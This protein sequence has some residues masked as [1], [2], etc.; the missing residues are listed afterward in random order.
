VVSV[1]GVNRVYN[2]T[3]GATVTLGETALGSDAVSASYGSAAFANK[4]VGN[5]KTIS[6]SGITLAGAD[7][8]NYSVNPSATTAADVTP[9]TLVVGAI[10]SNKPYDA[11]TAATVVLTDDRFAGDQILLSHAPATFASPGVGSGKTITVA[12]I[13]INGGAD[14]GDYVLADNSTTTTADIDVVVSEALAGTW[15][16]VPVMPDRLTPTMLPAALAPS[17]TTP[18]ISQLDL[19]LPTG[20]IGGT[21]TAAATGQVTNGAT[22]AANVAANDGQVTVVLVQ[23]WTSQSPGIVSVS[24]PEEM[25][26]AGRGFSFALP[27]SLVE[28]AGGGKLQITQQNGKRLPSWLRYEPTSN[29][30]SAGAVQ[31]GALPIELLVRSSTQRWI[32]SISEHVGS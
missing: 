9:A 20:F 21:A 31:A 30:I 3:T 13:A 32:L 18:A 11:M 7:A 14:R 5:G 12:G 8:G 1:T 2:A 16:L 10:G 6:V 26:T 4:N 29:R 17:V 24:V 27:A 28:A 23:A 15:S 22:P 19:T 25:V